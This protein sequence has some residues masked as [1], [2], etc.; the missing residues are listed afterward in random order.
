MAQPSLY[1]QCTQARGLTVK[2]YE[3]RETITVFDDSEGNST[4]ESSRVIARCSTRDRA[5]ELVGALN[6]C[7]DLSQ[8]GLAGGWFSAHQLGLVP[9]DSAEDMEEAFARDCERTG[10]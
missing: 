2:H 6:R 10:N 1:S 4:T 9:V 7:A 8:A 3:I 5:D